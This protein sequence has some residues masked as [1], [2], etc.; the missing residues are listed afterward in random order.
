ML[1][2]KVETILSMSR[3]GMVGDDDDVDVDDDEKEY[4][5]DFDCFDCS[6]NFC[7]CC[8][9]NCSLKESSSVGK[10][11]L[12]ISS[13]ISYR[14]RAFCRLIS[15]ASATSLLNDLSNVS[16][17]SSLT[18]PPLSSSLLPS[19]PVLPLPLTLLL[20]F[21]LIE[22]RMPPLS[23]FRAGIRFSALPM[24]PNIP[25]DLSPLSVFVVSSFSFSLSSLSSIVRFSRS[26]SL[27]IQF[28]SFFLLLSL[29][30]SSS[31]SPLAANNFVCVR[32]ECEKELENDLTA[33]ECA[34]VGIT[35]RIGRILTAV[36]VA[37]DDDDGGAR[38]IAFE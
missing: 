36:A 35:V 17:A 21:R 9:S 20:I 7:F 16:L 33:D 34:I 3:I 5:N 1:S 25:V 22:L 2:S 30:F 28:L 11:A 31:S 32:Y 14:S 37:G 4:D 29:L 38:L 15:I 12:G 24:Y 10:N 27:R 19:V 23:F 6:F 18:P 13:P 26:L 8:C